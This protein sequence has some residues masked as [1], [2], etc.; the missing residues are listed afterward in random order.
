MRLLQSIAAALLGKSAYS[1]GWP[2][3]AL[4][5]ALHFLIATCWAALFILVARSVSALR[6]YAVPSG[7][8]YGLIV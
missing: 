6:R 5:L 3:A 4:G 1:G 2:T 8:V 7:M